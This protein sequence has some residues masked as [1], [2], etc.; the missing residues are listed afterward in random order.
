MPL[1]AP[2][3]DD[4][5][6]QS[7]VDDAKRLVQ[8][9]CPE[10]TDHNVSDPGVTLIETFA[11]MV[12]QLLWRL[13]Q[14]PD[15]LYVK[16]LELLGVQLEA[17]NAARAPITFWLSAPQEQTVAVPAGTQIA[18]RRTDAEPI[19]FTTLA[20]LDI[21]PCAFE[22]AATEIL[23]EQVDRTDELHRR[24][25]F[26][27]FSEVPQVGDSFYVGLSNAVPSCA[28]ALRFGLDTEGSG[29]DPRYPPLAWEAWDGSHWA[30]CEVESDTTGGLNRDGDVVLHLP[31]THT[32]H[33]GVT[34]QLA[35]WVRCRVTP[36]EEWQPGYT[37]SPRVKRLSAFTKGG[38]TQ[39]VHADV[40]EG[41]VVGTSEGV[42]AQRF[43]LRHRPVVHGEERFGH[44]LEV[45]GAGGV[46]VWQE[47][48]TFGTSGPRDRH[49][50]ID[51]TAG[52]VVFGPAVRSEDGKLRHYGAV[53]A[54]HAGIRLREYRHGGGQRGNVAVGALGV[55]KSS[56]PL[57][58]TVTNRRPALGGTDGETM[59]N[60]KVRGPLLLQT[61]QRAVTAEDYEALACDAAKE[62]ARARCVPA[63]VDGVEAGTVRVLLV[64]QVDDGQYGSLQFEQL[65]PEEELVERVRAYLDARRVIGTRLVVE[66]ADYVGVTVAAILRAEPAADPS[67]VRAAALTAVYRY[68][69]PLRG[70]PDGT[71]WPFGN[72]VATWDVYGVLQAVPGV[73]SAEDVRLFSAD[74]VEHTRSGQVE[75]IDIG[76][77]H[78]F[79]SVGHQ[80]RV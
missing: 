18:T 2:H 46:E 4:R 73:A 74:P 55:V 66:P 77:N 51:P 40:V 12:D 65:R 67:T 76:P 25:G 15:R 64:P 14:V 44:S 68:L 29:V 56:V 61:R 20:P 19:T 63:G 22:R 11:Y 38:T 47:V 58:A 21:V 35:G 24:E 71:G 39:A 43:T 72:R 1:P 45:I 7:L 60:A 6:F 33:V 5:D 79:F 53:P 28:I 69:H 70:G 42:P 62:V 32:A 8:Q 78:L 54:K 16:F 50:M 17:P 31:R 52:E 36:T 41:E 57:I 30:P 10:W 48:G 49:F 23:G 26:A 37:S 3:L 13:N 34:R 59:D 80:I 75:R 27:C 9:R